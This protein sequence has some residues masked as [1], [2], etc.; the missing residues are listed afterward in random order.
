MRA[1]TGRITTISISEK[2]CTD[3]YNVDPSMLREKNI[4][5]HD[6]WQWQIGCI[7]NNKD[8]QEV[9]EF[10]E[11]ELTEKI[12]EVE[13]PTTGKILFY[14][15]SKHINNPCDGGFW[16]IEQLK[17][18]S[19]GQR[20]KKF[21]GLSNGSLVDCYVGIGE[22]VVDIYRPNPNAKEVYVASEEFN[23]GR[24]HWYL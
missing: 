9:L 6:G 14:R 23:Y 13:H 19:K 21:K 8:L 10:L 1:N 4:I 2:T 22:N 5:I 15:L 12:D 16:S 20:L 11:I 3:Y 24:N 18:M 17:E 7:H